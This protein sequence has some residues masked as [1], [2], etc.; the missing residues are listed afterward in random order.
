MQSSLSGAARLL[1]RRMTE[2]WGVNMPRLLRGSLAVAAAGSLLLALLGPVQA[3]TCSERLQV[4]Y[5]YCAK[6]M[7]DSPRCHD[8][9]RQYHQEC[10][11]SGCWESKV[12]AR[13]CGF[14][15]Q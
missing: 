13:E 8:K 1:L 4:C 5:G 10:M 9:C 7:G 6:S 3:K 14:A 2:E 12:V 15:R 11:E